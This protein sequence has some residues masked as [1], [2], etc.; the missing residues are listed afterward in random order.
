M[1]PNIIGWSISVLIAITG[2]WIA[3]TN[4]NKQ[5]RRNLDLDNQKFVRDM[6]I[7][8]ADEAIKLLAKSRESLGELNLY[9]ILLPGDLRMKYAVDF[10]IS[11][12]RW[13]KPNEQILQLWEDSSKA[14]LEFTYFF[15]SREIVL[16]QFT[17]MKQVYLDQLGEIR[18]IISKYSEYLGSIYYSKYLSGIV[19]SEEEMRVFETKTNE[20]NEYVFDF[21]AYIHDFIVELQNSYLSKPFGYS[22][23]VREPTDPKYKVLRAK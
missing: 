5:H 18:T 11:I 21:L 15:E 12:S 1:W 22:I 13:K 7:K 10:E 17:E 14:I 9:L 19:L 2:W 16:N 23:P 8:T 6:Q 4:L 20:I 3:I